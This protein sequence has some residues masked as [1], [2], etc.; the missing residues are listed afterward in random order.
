MDMDVDV[1]MDKSA[2]V[3]VSVYV[4]INCLYACICMVTSFYFLRIV[5][6]FLDV[7]DYQVKREKR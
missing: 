5:R 7:Q 1:D 3:S 6:E 2:R 4:Y